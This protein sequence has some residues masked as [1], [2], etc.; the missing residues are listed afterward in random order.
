VTEVKSFTGRWSAVLAPLT[1]GVGVVSTVAFLLVFRTDAECDWRSTTHA[2]ANWLFAVGLALAVVG[3]V[4]AVVGALTS[5]QRWL[6]IVAAVGLAVP[7]LYVV[8]GIVA[9]GGS[10]LLGGHCSD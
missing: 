3:V 4:L 10:P 5:R 6:W 1:V 2:V 8:A 7:T 9:P